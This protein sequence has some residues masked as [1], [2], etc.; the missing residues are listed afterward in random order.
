MLNPINKQ[1]IN[2]ILNA[3]KGVADVDIIKNEL[4]IYQSLDNV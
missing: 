3:N 4:S 2:E 1:N